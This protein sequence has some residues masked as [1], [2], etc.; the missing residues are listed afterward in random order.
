[1]S[2]NSQSIWFCEWGTTVLSKSL[3]PLCSMSS[4]IA[5][6]EGREQ[7]SRTGTAAVLTL[8]QSPAPPLCRWVHRGPGRL[9]GWGQ[10]EEPTGQHNS[11]C[12][13]DC[14]CSRVEPSGGAA[15]QEPW[16]PSGARGPQGGPFPLGR[17]PA[18][19]KVVGGLAGIILVC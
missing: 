11:V 12:R 13:V 6:V 5:G 14:G 1:M 16:E 2:C 17:F 7:G 4:D 15:S 10:N 3:A 18:E 19:G 8:G 9:R